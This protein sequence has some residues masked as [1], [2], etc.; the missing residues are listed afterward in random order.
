MDQSMLI[1]ALAIV[2]HAFV[3]RLQAPPAVINRMAWVI[4]VLTLVVLMLASLR[5]VTL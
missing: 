4:T 1:V 3:A 5:R 2:A